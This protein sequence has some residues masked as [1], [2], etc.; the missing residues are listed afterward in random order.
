MS[1]PIISIVSPV[2]NEAEGLAEFVRQVV[3]V[4]EP[5]QLSFEL[6]LVNDGSRDATLQIATQIAAVDNRIRV[7]SFSRNFGHE[8]ASTAGI[9]LH[10]GDIESPQR[11]GFRRRLRKCETGQKRKQHGVSQSDW[12]IHCYAMEEVWFTPHK[13]SFQ[14]PVR[15]CPRR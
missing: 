11:S 15:H 10:R 7:I 2:Y 13:L 9:G 3:A 1:Q 6:V 12:H 14:K 4:M 8:A 5:L